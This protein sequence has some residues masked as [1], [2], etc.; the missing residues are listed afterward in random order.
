[1]N[2]NPNIQS[3]LQ[4]KVLIVEDEALTRTL[5]SKALES[6][7]FDVIGSV[8]TA[9]L[10]MKLFLEFKPDVILLD[11]DLGS[12]PNG[13]D[14]ANAVHKINPKT[15][16][17]FISSLEDVRKVRPN[18]PIPPP[19]SKFIAKQEVKEIRLLID[20]VQ[21]AYNAAQTSDE[22]G[23]VEMISKMRKLQL[24]DLQIELMRL[25]ALGLSNAAIAEARFTT[26]KSTE[27]AISRLAKKLLLE[28]TD[29]NNQRVLIA[30]RFFQNAPSAIRTPE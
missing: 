11:I 21:S 26:V 1:M 23:K 30:Q 20:L 25:I 5:I 28:K 4:Y 10:A 18:L 8:N 2:L 24:T 3:E 12:G 16:I 13:I 17:A 15:G 19:I 7:M 9:T 14:I 29:K 22:S 6:A 27:N